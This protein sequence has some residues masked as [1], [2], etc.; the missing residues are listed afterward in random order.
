MR[1]NRLL[2]VLTLFTLT[3]SAVLA[4]RPLTIDDADPVAPGDAE[5]EAGAA[6]VKTS[7]CDHW[8]FPAGLAIGA[9]PK[10]ELNLGFGGQFEERED[11]LPH[12]GRTHRLREE[13]L[14]DLVA[15]AKWLAWV[16][17]G[18]GPRHAL[19][20]AVKFPTADEDKG[21][22]SG[23]TDYDLT[24]I[25]SAT[26]GAHL[27]VHVNAGYSWIGT[28][29][30]EDV[31]D[32][33]HYGAALDYPVCE[34]IQWVGELFA[35]RERRTGADTSVLFNTGLRW[36]VRESLIVD[37]AAGAGL[38]DDSP[39]FICTAGFTWAFGL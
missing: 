1:R 30:G 36:A 37:L 22:G 3:A 5:L 18:G 29:E 31:G 39:D 15:G 11:F 13:G 8:D 20:A 38:S 7:D 21:L 24:W 12:T 6:F 9:L 14:G 10:L 2:P 19:A 35:E 16:P 26:L 32:V 4:A 27:G 34:N 25:A 23:E 33:V 17:D 28:P